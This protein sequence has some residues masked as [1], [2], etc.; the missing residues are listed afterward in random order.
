MRAG[1]KLKGRNPSSAPT[2]AAPITTPSVASACQQMIVSVVPMI[3]ATPE[4]EPVEPVQQVHGVGDADDPDRGEE[5][6]QPGR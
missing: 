6:H 4:H 2:K 1:E 5:R 3:A